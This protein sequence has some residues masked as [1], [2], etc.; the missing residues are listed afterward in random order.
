M[1]LLCSSGVEPKIKAGEARSAELSMFALQLSFLLFIDSTVTKNQVRTFCKKLE[2]LLP[3][4][5]SE[6]QT[7]H[8][9]REAPRQVYKGIFVFILTWHLI[10][11]HS[12]VSFLKL[13]V[14]AQ[15]LIQTFTIVSRAL[16]IA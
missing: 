12:R 13:R 10:E 5:V 7:K 4:Q 3:E 16:K 9:R 8:P 2:H 11:C 1:T 14:R 6:P 15:V